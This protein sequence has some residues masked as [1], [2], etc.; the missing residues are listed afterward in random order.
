MTRPVCAVSACPPDFLQ[1]REGVGACEQLIPLAAASVQNV[2]PATPRRERRHHLKLAVNGLGRFP[3]ALRVVVWVQDASRFSGIFAI[4]P[5]APV[6]AA[7][8][9]TVTAF[10]G[11]Y[12]LRGGFSF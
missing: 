8:E 11:V 3:F 12:W 7:G 1:L 2:N 4:L 9:H 10:A 6:R 5:R